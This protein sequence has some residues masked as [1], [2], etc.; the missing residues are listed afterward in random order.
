MQAAAILQIAMILLPMIQT[1]IPQLIAWME[2]LRS[3]AKQAGEWSDAQDKA[4]RAALLAKT[5]D[6]AYAQD[7]K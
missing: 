3:A 1:G 4:Y 6:P 5:G 2:S 7:P